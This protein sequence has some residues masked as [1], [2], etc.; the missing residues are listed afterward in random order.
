M[1]RSLAVLVAALLTT[2]AASAQPAPPYPPGVIPVNP[3]G[4]QRGIQQQ[5]TSGQVGTVTVFNRGPQPTLRVEMKGSDNRV[6][7]VRIYRGHECPSDVSVPPSY[8]L[9]DLRSGVSTSVVPLDFARLMS[10]NYN[11]VVFSS[12]Q[13]GARVV[14]CGHL[15]LS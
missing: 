11:L 14:A 12:N 10:G 1:K 13:A 9:T 3:A 8:S 15:Y 7:W 5:N 4:I 6:E 2:A